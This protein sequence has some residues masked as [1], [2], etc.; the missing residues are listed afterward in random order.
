MLHVVNLNLMQASA[1]HQADGTPT[2]AHEAH[3]RDHILRLRLA[4]RAALLA[5]L[6]KVRGWLRVRP[7]VM[8]GL[9]LR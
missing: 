1:R 2:D 7:V 3:R 9:R 8:K 5:A 4:R 6:R